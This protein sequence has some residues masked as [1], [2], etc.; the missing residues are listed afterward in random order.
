MDPVS[1]K[2][3]GILR[4]F[5][6]IADSGDEATTVPT[7]QNNLKFFLDCLYDLNLAIVDATVD[8][9]SKISKFA[10]VRQ[11]LLAAGAISS[12]VSDKSR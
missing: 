11:S 1:E 8:V 6:S 7:L 9:L 3:L 10:K 12:L 5:A 4:A 2:K